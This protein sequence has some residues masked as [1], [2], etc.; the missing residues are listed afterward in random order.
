[1]TCP[2]MQYPLHKSGIPSDDISIAWPLADLYGDEYDEDEDEDEDDSDAVY[3]DEDEWTTDDEYDG[4]PDPRKAGV[5]G[6][7]R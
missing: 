2:L 7:S 4:V 1:M 5:P 6:G 3:T